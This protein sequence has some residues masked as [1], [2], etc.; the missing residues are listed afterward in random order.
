MHFDKAYVISLEE[1]EKRR[2][3]F[4][5]KADKAGLEVEWFHAIRGDKV[6]TQSLQK[7]GVLSVD[8][9]PYQLGSLGTL[10]SHTATWDL[11]VNS[12]HEIGLIM[13]DDALI[14]RNF[15]K[16]LA[17]IDWSDIPEDWDMLWLAWHKSSCKPVTKYVGSPI[18]ED[19]EK[20]RGNSGH[21]CYL[22]KSSSVDKM[23]ALLYPYDNKHAKDVMLRNNFENFN[24]YFMKKKLASTPLIEFDSM[25]KLINHGN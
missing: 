16:K 17:K 4:L 18:V 8:F 12:E 19:G 10:L 13:E 2:R 1:S 15:L 21:Y 14:P 24:G 11:I 22:I 9:K 25:R 7:K 20:R 23:K 3:R 6:D 5:K